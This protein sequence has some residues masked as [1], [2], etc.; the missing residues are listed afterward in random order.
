MGGEKKCDPQSPTCESSAYK[1]PLSRTD[2]TLEERM[3]DSVTSARVG[4]VIPSS[5]PP[6]RR[7]LIQENMNEEVIIED[8]KKEKLVPEFEGRDNSQRNANAEQR[9]RKQPQNKEGGLKKEKPGEEN[10]FEKERKGIKA[11]TGEANGESH[12]KTR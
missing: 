9:L 6:K 2:I 5:C 8:V 7:S 1:F 4:G 3:T 12:G 11:I 10:T